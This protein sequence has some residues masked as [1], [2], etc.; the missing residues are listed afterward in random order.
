MAQSAYLTA[1]M[2]VTDYDIHVRVSAAA[3][4]ESEAA[5]PVL[6]DPET[7]ARD[8]AWDYGTQTDWVAAV[9]SAIDAGIT[10]WGKDPV[11]ITDQHILSYVQSVM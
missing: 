9:M 2:I 11:V 10:D 7:W 6:D 1:Y 3:R 5:P 8:H 4:Q